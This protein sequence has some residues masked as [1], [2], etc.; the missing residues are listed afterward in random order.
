MSIAVAVDT[1]NAKK[2]AKSIHS[3]FRS[4]WAQNA[5]TVG[6]KAAFT[7]Y[8]YTYIAKEKA[9]EEDV[10][11]AYATKTEDNWEGKA[12]KI[13]QEHKGEKRAKQWWNAYKK[14]VGGTSERE[15]LSNLGYEQQ[16]DRMRFPPGVR[17]A[18]EDKYLAFRKENNKKIPRAIGIVSDSSRASL[19]KK[20]KATR[21]L[22]QIAWKAAYYA[23]GGRGNTVSV[24]GARPREWPKSLLKV[25]NKFGKD[26]L[27]GASV[28]LTGNGFRVTLE[29]HVRY[30][31]TAFEEWGRSRATR[32]VEKYMKILFDLKRKNMK[33]AIEN[34][35]I[36][37]KAA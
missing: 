30:M 4:M 19:I 13:I 10:K 35:Q 34:R 27:G 16:F 37:Q 7:C 3:Q 1:T 29:N 11:T 36:A 20:R 22:A 12:F 18:K 33:K 25:Y 6:K 14:E 28:H 32:V 21:G 17:A 8:E 26:N 2:K 31:D 24:M 15:D 23:L 5:R 9:I